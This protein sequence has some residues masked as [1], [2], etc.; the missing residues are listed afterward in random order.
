[1]LGVLTVI[2]A[3]RNSTGRRTVYLPPTLIFLSLVLLAAIVLLP[4]SDEGLRAGLIVLEIAVLVTSF[5][6]I[7][8]Q[9]RDRLGEGQRPNMPVAAAN[10]N[11]AT[12][13][14][15]SGSGY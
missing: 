6:Q 2:A 12:I 15:L 10:A 4:P 1:V 5:T 3:R 13:S 8:P 11:L 9:R 14:I 7:R